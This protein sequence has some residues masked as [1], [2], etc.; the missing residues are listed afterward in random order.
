MDRTEQ[1]QAIR[2]TRIFS[3]LGDEAIDDIADVIRWKKYN[4]GAKVISF[5]DTDTRVYFLAGGRVRATIFSYSGKEVSYQEMGPGSMFGELSAIDKK[6]RTT[7]IITTEPSWIGSISDAAFWNLIH[8]YPE[9]ASGVLSRVA[10]LVRYLTDRVYKYGALDV[11]DRVRAE[12]LGLAREHMKE[13]DKAVIEKM[14]THAEIANR[15]NTHREAVTR[16]LNE[17]SRTGLIEQTGRILTVH[18]VDALAELLPED[19]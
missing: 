10:S 1:N 5:R 13:G 18:S 15:V 3:E 19:I 6:P 17:L 16:E 14:P 2:N 8:T 11:K 7:N 4:K 12:V 9:V